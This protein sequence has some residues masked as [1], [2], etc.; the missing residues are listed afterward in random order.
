MA[1][2]LY[3]TKISVVVNETKIVHYRLYIHTTEYM[4]VS[5]F[6][7]KRFYL[8]IHE[9]HRDR[10]RHR[11]REKQAPCK[12]LDAGLDLGPWDHAQSQ[13]QTLNL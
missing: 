4:F 12:K 2:V 9:R 11:Q 5:S 6:F 8:L 13:R 10:Q 3:E 1:D 7:K